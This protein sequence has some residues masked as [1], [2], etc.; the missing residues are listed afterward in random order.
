MDNRD[1]KYRTVKLKEIPRSAADVSRIYGCDLCA[2]LKSVVLVGVSGVVLVVLPGDRRICMEKLTVIAGEGS[3]RMATKEEVKD[4]TGY[5]VG[6]VTPFGDMDGITK[7]VD[8]SVFDM[9]TV[10]I[11]SG[12]AEIGIEMETKEFCRVWDG[13]VADVVVVQ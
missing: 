8:E 13:E 12:V 10:N 2:V 11:G 9:N 3:Y 7:I 6:G 5:P 1:A 4:I